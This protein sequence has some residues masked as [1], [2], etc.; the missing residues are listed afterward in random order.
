[1][2]LLARKKAEER[3]A[4]FLLMIAKRVPNMGFPHAVNRGGIHFQ[5]PLSRA[6]VSDCLGLTIETVRRQ[7]TRLKTKGV[8]ELINY[9]EIVIPDVRALQEAAYE[10][11]V[12]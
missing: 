10:A 8:I 1:M 6:E 9:R 11:S 4:S 5:L 2:L 7:M 3:V 12:A